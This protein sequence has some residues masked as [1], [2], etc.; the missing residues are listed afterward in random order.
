MKIGLKARFSDFYEIAKLKPDFVEFHFSDLDPD[1]D[2]NPKMKYPFSCFIHLPEMWS[3]HMIDIASIRNENQVLPLSE[4]IEV[5][6][7]IISKSERF[8]KYFNN[9]ENVFILHPGGMSFDKDYPENN[10]HRIETL[11]ESLSVIKTNNSEILI[12]N[13]PPYPWYFG[14]QWN[15]NIF[16]DA[17]EIESFCRVTK[18]NICYDISHSKLYCNSSKKDLFEELKIIKKYIRHVHISDAR[19]VDGEGIQIGE[20]EIDFKKFFDLMKD[21][22]GTI[23]NEIWMGY[24]NDFQGFKIATQKIKKYLSNYS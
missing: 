23:V 5:L 11:I 14:G 9:K 18:K 22:H 12:E 13:L 4:S 20:G 6:Q 8:F 16:M 2:F 15:S 3:G 21:Y 10:V 7:K 17:G 24:T 1:F 19:G